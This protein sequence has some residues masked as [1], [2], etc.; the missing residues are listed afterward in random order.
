MT[1][2]DDPNADPIGDLKK[3]HSEMIAN[4]LLPRSPI[5]VP[6]SLRPY[7]KTKDDN[8]AK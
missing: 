1:N 3:A 2:W 5:W 7:L 6:P 8:A 4:R